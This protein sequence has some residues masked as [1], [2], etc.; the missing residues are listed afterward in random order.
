MSSGSVGKVLNARDLR[1]LVLAF[2]PPAEWFLSTRVCTAWSKLHLQ[3]HDYQRAMMTEYEPGEAFLRPRA[4]W[5]ERWEWAT[6]SSLRMLDA[7]PKY[8]F[9]DL[10]HPT[11]RPLA[12]VCELGIALARC[13]WRG[14]HTIDPLEVVDLDSGR[15]TGQQLLNLIHQNI[16]AHARPDGSLAL[17]WSHM[18]T[19]TATSLTLQPP[20]L[21]DSC[22]AAGHAVPHAVAAQT[23]AE[24]PVLLHSTF[25]I[26]NSLE[27]WLP[28]LDPSKPFMFDADMEQGLIATDGGALCVITGG[29]HPFK[30][31]ESL[32]SLTFAVA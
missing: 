1:Q 5:K 9:S 31:R 26:P 4:T 30:V 17:F 21:C 27:P 24:E 2:L 8:R 12:I 7:A 18:H 19:M 22:A 15:P 13:P 10:F 3:E 29:A 25:P 20:L 6:E 32:F 28:A 23:G 11:F 14:R 16:V